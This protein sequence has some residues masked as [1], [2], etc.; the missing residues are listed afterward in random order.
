MIV[1]ATGDGITTV[2]FIIRDSTN[3]I[4][5]T[6]LACSCRRR[7]TRTSQA[8]VPLNLSRRR[9]RARNSASRRSPSTRPDASATRFPR[10]ARLREGHV[11]LRRCVDSTLVVYGR[12]YALPQ[13]GTD[14]RH[15]RRRRAR[16]R[17]PVEH[18]ISTCSTSGRALRPAKGF[19]PNGDRRR[20]AAVGHVHLEQPGHAA[21]RELRR[22]EHQ[23]RVHRVDERGEPAR[24]SAAS[25]PD[26][27]YV[28]LHVTVQRDENTGKIRLT[29]ARVRSATRIAHSTSRSRRAAASSTRRVRRRLRRPAR[30][31]WLDPSLAG[32]GSA[33]DLAVRHHPNKSRS[34]R[35]RCSTWTR[36]AI[37]ATLPASTALGHA[38]H[39]GSSVRPE[40]GYHRRLRPGFR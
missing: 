5:Q 28:R 6:R 8:N 19:A 2:G 25:H 40:D 17:L 30:I 15:R 33:T 12:T 29:G 20:L 23:P 21:R 39:L 35:T 22:Y 14:R 10:R 11:N 1:R 34:R 16:Q 31:R 4:V 27:Q 36:S 32:S 13:Q 38:L 9:C 3:T 26:A 7:S 18:R 37:G 24:G